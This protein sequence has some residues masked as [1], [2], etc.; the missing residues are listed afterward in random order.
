MEK[1]D[2]FVHTGARSEES[3]MTVKSPLLLLPPPPHIHTL[4]VSHRQKQKPAKS[5]HIN[6]CLCETSVHAHELLLNTH[7]HRAQ[8]RRSIALRRRRYFCRLRTDSGECINHSLRPFFILFGDYPSRPLS[9][10]LPLTWESASLTQ[11]ENSELNAKGAEIQFA[12]LLR[13]TVVRLS[14]DIFCFVFW[15]RFIPIRQ[16]THTEMGCISKLN[17]SILASAR[18][19]A[20]DCALYLVS[21]ARLARFA[22]F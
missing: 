8:T 17:A 11:N 9:L 21:N 22:R 3:F 10:S 6:I 13:S 16:H 4:S 14:R 19:S 7:E 5:K 20:V 18:C 2:R 15:I 12:S 1:N